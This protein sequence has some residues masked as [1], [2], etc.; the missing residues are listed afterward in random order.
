[1]FSQKNKQAAQTFF[2]GLSLDATQALGQINAAFNAGDMDVASY[3]KALTQISSTFEYIAGVVKNFGTQMGMTADEISSVTSNMGGLAQA[4]SQLAQMQQL[5]IDLEGAMA[6]QAEGT[7]DTTS[8]SYT[9]AMTQIAS[10]AASSGQTFHDQAGNVLSS[11]QSIYSYITGSAANFNDFAN[12][13]ANKTGTL[14]QTILQDIGHLLVDLGTAISSMHITMTADV[15]TTE[16]DFPGGSLQLPTGIEFNFG[17]SGGGNIASEIASVVTDL[18]KTLEGTSNNWDSSIYTMPQALNQVTGAA[19][20]AAGAVNDLGKALTSAAAAGSSAASDL[21]SQ[22]DAAKTAAEDA[23][24]AQ[25]AGYKGVVDAREALLDSLLAEQTYNEDIANQNKSIADI[26]NKLTALQFD[27]SDAANAERLSL[28]DQLATAEQKLTDAQNKESVDVQKSAL[29]ADYASFQSEIQTA[30]DN[31]KA[32]NATSM[33]D[34]ANQLSK[35]LATIAQPPAI[36]PATLAIPSF[37]SGGWVG[38]FPSSDTGKI[39]AQLMRGEFVNTPSQISDFMSK[40]LPEIASV[41]STNNSANISFGSLITVQ[42]NVDSSVIP[43][44]QSIADNVINQLN[45]ALAQ[46]GKIRLTGVTAV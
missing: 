30:V 40:T 18:G 33:S 28:Q 39:F 25:L 41:S 31:V 5:N 16:W 3:T 42:G 6:D 13:S 34:L 36:N 4:S 43:D 38:G 9:Q 24:N 23:L 12:Q 1:M 26:Q 22:L 7:L 35:I 14:V 17:M 19:G 10:A 27:Q 2:A 45:N 20:D 8:K 11:A 15:Q 21:T 29:D 37:D 46:R 32:I 44:M